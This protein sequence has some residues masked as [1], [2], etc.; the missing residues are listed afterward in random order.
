MP[1]GL[2]KD[3]HVTSLVD[4]LM[5]GWPLE[6]LDGDHLEMQKELMIQVFTEV[7]NR[8]QTGAG[9]YNAPNKFKPFFVSVIGPQSSGKST[10]L[11]F[12]FG[13]SFQVAGGRCTKGLNVSIVPTDLENFTNPFVVLDTEGLMSI[14]RS[15][16][17]F[18]KKMMLFTMAMSHTVII[19]VKGQINANMS[20]ILGIA[21]FALDKFKFQKVKPKLLLV[22]RDMS[23]TNK[24]EHKDLVLGIREMLDIVCKEANVLLKDVIEFDGEESFF[25]MPPAFKD[26]E[27]KDQY[28]GLESR[29]IAIK[30]P[31]SEMF[32]GQA[33]GLRKKILD[34]AEERE[35]QANKIPEDLR[36]WIEKAAKTWSS[37]QDCSDLFDIDRVSEL[38]LRSEIQE[39]HKR[40]TD[41]F[42]EKWEEEFNKRILVDYMKELKTN[43]R[44]SEHCYQKFTQMVDHSL[45]NLEQELIERIK[46]E[47]SCE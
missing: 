47:C 6:L 4:L 29:S 37:I 30:R 42:E 7:Q 38:R 44:N 5:K 15:D 11:N 1:N 33:M 12:L 35:R 34:V 2:S 24:E 39:T 40:L 22:L 43:K 19:N 18:D 28:A 32:I 10:L 21:V 25:L 45:G 13:G 36:K 41:E 9:K 23:M 14:E 8:H 16:P 27:D 17:E 20:N 46:L 31:M 3:Q 26:D